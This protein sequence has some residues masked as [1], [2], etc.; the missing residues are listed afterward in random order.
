[1]RW[2]HQVR[3][4]PASSSFAVTYPGDPTWHPLTS[5]VAPDSSVSVALALQFGGALV[6][7]VAS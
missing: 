2:D 7:A 3:D 4:A 1:L 6:R 5:T